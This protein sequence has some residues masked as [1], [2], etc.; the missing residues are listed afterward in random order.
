LVFDGAIG[1][2]PIASCACFGRE[3]GVC[4]ELQRHPLIK[5]DFLPAIAGISVPFARENLHLVVSKFFLRPSRYLSVIQL[6]MAAIV[7][8]GSF[9][10]KYE[11]MQ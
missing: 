5:S 2:E 1:F 11:I 4:D 3:K 10:V 7:N 9:H 6:L 8:A